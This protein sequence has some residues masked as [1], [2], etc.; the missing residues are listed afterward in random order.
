MLASY[1][2][3]I[4]PLQSQSSDLVI[5]SYLLSI[6]LSWDDVLGNSPLATSDFIP[7]ALCWTGGTGHCPHS[8]SSKHQHTWAAPSKAALKMLKIKNALDFTI[9]TDVS[10]LRIKV[11]LI[12]LVQLI[13]I[14]GHKVCLS[15]FVVTSRH[16]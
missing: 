6:Q 5:S 7:R 8:G 10:L 13:S 1:Q 16:H 9:R 12:I 3:I 15:G 2:H 14:E 4:I 11:S